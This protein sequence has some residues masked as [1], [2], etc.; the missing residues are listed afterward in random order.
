MVSPV[1]RDLEYIWDGGENGMPRITRPVAVQLLSAATK[2]SSGFLM[3]R[4]SE[5]KFSR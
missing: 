1:E 5:D 3:V 2:L 4:G